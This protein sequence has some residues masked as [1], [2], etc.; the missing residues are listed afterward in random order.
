MSVNDV[1]RPDGT[2]YDAFLFAIVG[3]DRNGASV[4][5]LSALA[6]LDLEPWAEARNLAGLTREIAQIRLSTH[7]NSITRTSVLTLS[8]ENGSA[9]LVDLLPK[10]ASPLDPSTKL[11]SQGWIDWTQLALIGVVVLAVILY[12]AQAG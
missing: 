4:T 6:R 9:M 1:L 8:S 7:L 2:E 12:L 10:H 3:D 11:V 5:V